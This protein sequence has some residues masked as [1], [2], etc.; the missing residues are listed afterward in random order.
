ME[1]LT[2]LGI[3]WK[4]LVAQ[5]IN[6]GILVFVLYK[7]VYR[8]LLKVL[9]ERS[10]MVQDAKDKS[11]SVDAKLDE[12]KALE[13]STLA[14]SRKR[15][16]EIIKETEAAALVLK[17]RLEKDA[18][19]AATKVVREA[20]VRMK[21]EQEKMNASLKSEIKEI[22]ASAIE[23]TVGKYLDAG[24][25]HKLAEEASSEALKVEKFLGVK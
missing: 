23:S 25:K 8:P 15:G 20:E 5:I 1:L 14:E 6:F 7:L 3:E 12:I 10:Q 18:A 21:A 13:E 4:L 11:S 9:D 22:V 24:A 17:A 16:A 2:S 19:E